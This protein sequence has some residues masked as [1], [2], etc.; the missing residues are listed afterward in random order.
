MK[1]IVGFT[2]VGAAYAFQIIVLLI[3]GI[4]MV[5]CGGA[6]DEKTEESIIKEE[7]TVLKGTDLTLS[8]QE[9][10]DNGELEEVKPKKNNYSQLF[11]RDSLS[12]AV[13]KNVL[14]GTALYPEVKFGKEKVELEHKEKVIILTIINEYNNREQDDLR[15]KIIDY[16]D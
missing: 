4:S 1:K 11:V 10:F 2:P 3:I 7:T 16:C 5:A 9:M 13:V 15:K 6:K 8:I 12:I 14:T